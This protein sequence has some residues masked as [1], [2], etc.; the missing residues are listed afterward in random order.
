MPTS[1]FKICRIFGID[2]VINITWVLIL[3]L[4]AIS[5]GELFRTYTTDPGGFN[6]PFPGGIW[7]WAAGVI[8]TAIFFICLIA[9]E[10]SHSLVARRHGVEV[11]RITLFLFGGVAE[12]SGEVP[13]P[14]SEFKMAA[15]G[16]GASFVIAGLLFGLLFLANSLDLSTVILLPLRSLVEL[17]IA[18]GIFNLLPGFPMDGGRILRSII[19]KKTGDLQKSTRISTIIGKGLALTMAAGGLY[20]LF[21]NFTVAGIWLIFLGVFL[22]LIANASYKQ[23]LYNIAAADTKVDDIMFTHVPVVDAETTLTNLKL[24]YFGP[25]RLPVLPVAVNGSVIGIASEEDLEEVAAAEWELLNAGRIAKPIPVEKTVPPGTPLIEAMKSMKSF[26]DFIL[27]VK[28]DDI[29]GILSKQE[30]LNYFD[31]RI[32]LQKK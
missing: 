21:S 24:Q 10:L 2:I 28:E 6:Q 19:W 11:R 1:G 31:M 25:Y 9:H 5:F 8:T 26:S 32:K 30:L 12:M 29:L 4:L 16:P 23:T 27:I 22:Y 18:V 3:I 20:L 7:P 17:N 15:A 14:G 13:D